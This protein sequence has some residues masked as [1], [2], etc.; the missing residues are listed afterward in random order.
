ME[1]RFA[2][3]G[4]GL[5]LLA[6]QRGEQRDG[7]AEPRR[8]AGHRWNP[9]EQKLQNGFANLD[10]D[11]PHDRQAPERI[12]HAAPNHR[13][14]GAIAGG[15]PHRKR[16]RWDENRVAVAPEL[17]K[18]AERVVIRGAI[19]GRIL[20]E[21]RPVQRV[22]LTRKPCDLDEKDAGRG[23]RDDVGSQS[24]GQGDARRGAVD[25]KLEGERRRHEA[26]VPGEGLEAFAKG[27]SGSEGMAGH[28]E[29]FGRKGTDVREQSRCGTGLLLEAT[30]GADKQVFVD[31]TVHVDA[32]REGRQAE[33][34][35]CGFQP[36]P[37]HTGE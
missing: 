2:Q 20:P 4:E 36:H 13:A 12:S 22:R 34:Q 19:R 31:R 33:G 18:T 3:A 9:G 28:A 1:Q 7:G 5:F 15:Q 8:H 29:G 16:L 23:G 25:D 35:G 17:D 30:K 21:H 24:G 32:F 14:H 37:D 11:G 10:A 27:G 6:K 26:E